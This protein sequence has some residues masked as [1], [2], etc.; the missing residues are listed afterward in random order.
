MQGEVDDVTRESEDHGEEHPDELHN[1]G[2]EDEA[3]L[4]GTRKVAIRDTEVI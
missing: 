3:A 1:H 4:V 2:L